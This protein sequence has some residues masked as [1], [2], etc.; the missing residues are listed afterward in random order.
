M[1]KKQKRA[2]GSITT[3]R[4]PPMQ[5]K[6][7]AAVVHLQSTG[8]RCVPPALSSVLK[9]RTAFQPCFATQPKLVAL[10]HLFRCLARDPAG[11][12]DSGGSCIQLTSAPEFHE[13]SGRQMGNA[14]D[15]RFVEV[16]SQTHKGVCRSITT[17]LIQAR[18]RDYAGSRSGDCLERQ[19]RSISRVS[20][21]HPPRGHGRGT[22]GFTLKIST[23]RAAP[24]VSPC[25]KGFGHSSLHRDR[26]SPN[27]AYR[28]RIIP[29]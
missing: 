14:D 18:S 13:A 20:K 19:F 5:R 4:T 25:D 11:G 8:T 16:P 7:A 27:P 15:G 23:R 1:R 21:A 9:D 12:A 10:A 6:S 3:L 24:L 17:H 22:P 26:R 28:C 29:D 2:P